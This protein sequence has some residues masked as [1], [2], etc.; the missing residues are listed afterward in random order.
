MLRNNGYVP[1]SALRDEVAH[2]DIFNTIWYL[3]YHMGTIPI[4]KAGRLVLPKEIRTRLHLQG[5]DLLEA[6][7]G[8]D[9]VTLR[10]V[11]WAPARIIQHNGRAIWDAPGETATVEDFEA[12]LQR[13]RAE[14][15]SR[16]VRI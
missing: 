1:C 4:D 6:S 12:A 2:L 3:F 10:P 8:P 16:A 9:A 7:I 5:G 11:R 14:R 13:G 15:D